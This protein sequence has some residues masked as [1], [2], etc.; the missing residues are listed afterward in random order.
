MP[1][2]CPPLEISLMKTRYVP[3]AATLASLL[4]AAGAA[5]QTELFI[6]EYEFNRAQMSAVRPDG[7]FP[8]TM[9]TLPSE[10]WLPIGL[11][12][13]PSTGKLI[14]MDSAGSSKT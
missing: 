3:A 4:L 5:A 2:V 10:L 12:Y 6:S 13:V 8:R 7:T 14:W 1:D 9:F 11:T